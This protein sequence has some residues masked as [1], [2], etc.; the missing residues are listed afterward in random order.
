MNQ[1]FKIKDFI[2]RT[3][4]IITTIKVL[5]IS[6]LEFEKLK[7]KTCFQFNSII[8]SSWKHNLIDYSNFNQN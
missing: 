6:Y 2:K 3:A 5:L 7:N 1:E 4:Q 8:L